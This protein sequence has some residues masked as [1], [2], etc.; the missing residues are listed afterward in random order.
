VPSYSVATY[1]LITLTLPLAALAASG[2]VAAVPV[3][4]HGPGAYPS[5]PL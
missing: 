2:A 1:S 3:S 5:L 4:R